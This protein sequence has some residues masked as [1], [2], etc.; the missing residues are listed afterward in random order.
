MRFQRSVPWAGVAVLLLSACTQSPQ[1]K[2]AKYLEKG[3]K[4]FDRKNYAVAVLHFKTAAAAQPRDAEPYYQL[5]LAFLA[6]NDPNT[7]ASYFHKATELNP[8]HTLAQVKLAELM[9]SSR[10]KED[11]EEAQK[12]SSDVLA[13]LPDDV[14]ALNVLAVAELRLGKPES[15]EAH[16]E[17]AL[18]KSP[19][20]LK[21]SVALAQTRLSRKD[22]AGAEQALLQAATQAPKSPEPRVYLGGFYLAQG[23]TAEAEQQFRLALAIDPKHG[24]ALM[25]IGSMQVRAGQ[26]E[27][28]EQ[29]YRQVATLPDK[30]YKAVH[31]L[32]LFESGKR[33]QAVAEFEKLSAADRAD[34]NSR[35]NLVRAYLS[36]N[37]VDD[38]E[39]TLTA[40]LKKNGL[41]VDALLQRSRIYL[42]SGKYAEAQADLNQV[43][44]FRSDS[45]EAHYLLSKVGQA[46]HD[47]AF[48][49]QELGQVLRV[50]P[51]LLAARIELAQL[52]IARGG[53][54][55]A[56][57]LLD[58]TPPDQRAAVS[59]VVQ[60]NWAL[61]RL[62]QKAE[63]RKGIDQVLAAG[64]VPEAQL[65]D[66][67]LKLDQKDFA[68]ARASAEA[69]LSQSPEDMR[70]LNVVVQSYAAQN[71]LAAGLQKAREYGL[72]Q[73]AS[74]SV[75]QFLGHLLATGGDRAGARKAYEAALGAK[76]GLVNAELALA[77]LDGLEG[78]RDEARKRLSAV[79]SAHPGDVTGRLLF[80]QLEMNA[81]NNPAAIDQYRKAVGSDEKNAVALNGLAYLLAET[82]QP[83]EALRYAQK[84]KELAPDNA[85]VDDTLG[86][87]YFQKGMYTLAV[88]HLESANAKEGTARR[89]YHLAMAYLKAGDPK[90][91]RQAFDAAYKMDPNLPEAQAA[92]Q[93]LGITA[94]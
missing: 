63:A 68:G 9:S 58:E 39:K 27:Q 60:R 90:R 93:V 76:P 34:R 65:Q 46:R 48:Q 5:G 11:V 17:Q 25:S 75:Q 29:T 40:A 8:K 14:D 4:E 84:A 52:L 41:D 37:R 3:K 66:A 73:P 64:K 56:L 19:S 54:P 79:L 92:R 81:G 30:Q 53:A 89:K 13:I 67:L 36:V 83:D 94:N 38:A 23:K 2:E 71:Q 42:G 72:R 62:G 33:D 50:D 12:R 51:K 20:N 6:S 24:P 82:K 74:A 47:A 35:T 80:A 85:A 86:W 70:A 32:Y 22:L 59:V 45:T 57:Q 18:R 55:S 88:T 21:S 91:G 87:T 10:R 7:A 28:A 31:A 15:A 1:A 61:L 26:A 49:K 44:H 78:K 77:E 16:L 43:L 69:A